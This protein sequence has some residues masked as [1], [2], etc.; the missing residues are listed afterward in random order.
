LLFSSFEFVAYFLPVVL[1]TFAALAAQRRRF[2]PGKIL[3]ILASA[4]FYAW[5]SLRD[6]LILGVLVLANYAF[7][8][9]I[10]KYR[11]LGRLRISRMLA[12]GGVALNLAVLMVFKYANLLAATIFDLSGAPAPHFDIVLPLGISFFTFQKIA[13]LVDSYKTRL[14]RQSFSSF[15]LF[16]SFFPQLIAGP[17]VHHREMMPQFDRARWRRRWSVHL[18]V[19]MTLFVIG[20]AKKVL[21]ADTLSPFV[22]PVF[23]AADQGVAIS[24][25]EAWAALLAYTFQL[26]F[27]FSGYS[28]MALGLARC[29]GIVLPA[30]FYSPYQSRSIVDFWRR[31]HI[32][33]SRFLRDYLYIPF[34]GNRRG[35]LRRYVNLLATMAIGGLWHGA[36]WT[37]LW[38]GT[39]HGVALG[40]NHW[41][42]E[43]VWPRVP[44]RLPGSVAWLL[45]L[46]FVV[47]A[48]I[49]FRAATFDGAAALLASVAGRE[50]LLPVRLLD[51]LGPP[52]QQLHALASDASLVLSMRDW[53]LSGAPTLVLA[54]AIALFGP[55]SLQIMRRYTPALKIPD[56]AQRKFSLF[57]WRPTAPWMTATLLLLTACLLKLSDVSEFLYFQF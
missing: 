1:L 2:A 26:Y 24:G 51:Q 7:S 11:E 12:V 47:L 21:I 27:D 19:G 49:P 17:I 30:N 48:W 38:W 56:G 8:T 9:Q 43:T 57:E 23:E 25:I 18:A 54:A 28:D 40:L 37:F 32:T 52:G 45:T 53:A 36:S 4:V 39:L 20:L 10:I 46:G 29:F 14:P 50:G 5:W 33:L 35:R 22:G 44:A 55:N 15:A 13:F 34:G 3:L 6:A 42:R 41:L 31:W 16:V